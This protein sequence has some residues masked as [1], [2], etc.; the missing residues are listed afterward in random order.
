MTTVDDKVVYFMSLCDQL[1][2]EPSLTVKQ[3]ILSGFLSRYTGSVEIL[4]K[5]LLPAHTHRKYFLGD[6]QLVKILSRM[7]GVE[8]KQMKDDLN[9]CGDMATTAARFFKKTSMC[10]SGTSTRT[11]AEI[12]KHLE[13]LA[14]GM[15]E[16]HQTNCI[17]KFCEG[18][19]GVDMEVFVRQIKQEMRLNAGIKCILS[20]LHPMAYEAFKTCANVGAVVRKVMGTS[21]GGGDGEDGAKADDTG[22]MSETTPHGSP[23]V[24]PP[25]S[26]KKKG[27]VLDIGIQLRTP[28]RP[29]LATATKTVEEVIAKCPNTFFSEVKYDGERIQIH[30][31]GSEYTFWARSLKPMK[32]DKYEGLDK[33]LQEAIKA[34]TCILDGEILLVDTKTSQ[35]LPFGT[36]G[37]HKK[38]LFKDANTGIFLFDILYLNGVSLLHQPL[39][40]RRELLKENVTEIKNRIL[41]SEMRH[42]KGTR[43]QQEFTLR[44]HL[45]VAIVE[46]LEGLVIKDIKSVYE[47]GMR[48]WIKI[49]KDYLK[50]MADTV[51][52]VVLGAWHGSGA[53]GGIL[54]TF[55][56]GVLDTTKTPSVWYTVC[57]VA[58]GHDDAALAAI[59]E[60][61][62]KKMV[63]V[64][65]K[66]T[67]KMPSWLNVHSSHIP[68]MIMIDPKTS[69]V[70]EVIGAQ[71]TKSAHHTANGI[72]FRFPRVVKVRD[73][74][75]WASATTLQELT[76]LFEVSM[77][78]ASVCGGPTETPRNIDDFPDDAMG[79]PPH[80]P[81]VAVP[82]L[83][84]T[85]LPPPPK[86]VAT[87]PPQPPPPSSST[88][89]YINLDVTNLLS[90][91]SDPF[92]NRV[93][94]HCVAA[95]GKWSNKGTMGL[96]ERKFGDVADAYNSQS[97]TF[98]L[99]DIQ[100]VQ[101]SN[102]LSKGKLY[103]LNLIGQPK[104][105]GGEGDLA[106]ITAGLEKAVQYAATN[107]ASLHVDVRSCS[108][109][110][111]WEGV[112][113]NLMKW[114][115]QAGVS[116]VC[117][118]ATDAEVKR[119]Q[120]TIA[121]PPVP[122]VVSAPPAPTTKKV[123][124]ETEAPVSY[125][126]ASPPPPPTPPLPKGKF[127]G[128]VVYVEGPEASKVATIV[129]SHGGKVS[130]T[131][132]AF[133]PGAPTH[134][135]TSTM[136]PA[137]QHAADV[138]GCV[139]SPQWVYD[140]VMATSSSLADVLSY[141]V[142]DELSPKKMCTESSSADLGRV[143]TGSFLLTSPLEGKSFVIEGYSK[144]DKEALSNKITMLGGSVKPTWSSG[145]TYLI[146]ETLTKTFEALEQRGVQVVTRDW[147]EAV[148]SRGTMVD[149]KPY[150]YTSR[151]VVKGSVTPPRPVP[152]KRLRD[153]EEDGSTLPPP[154]LRTT[155]TTVPQVHQKQS[156]SR[157]SSNVSVATPPV[158][159]TPPVS[160][161]HSTTSTVDA[162]YTEPEVNDFPEIYCGRCFILLGG[163]KESREEMARHIVAL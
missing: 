96:L 76:K 113:S 40:R 106:A 149:P 107:K 97:S 20:A 10:S 162:K 161:T 74:K 152:T 126:Y 144:K 59:N 155:S 42:A 67:A 6:K 41:Y 139:V 117:Y 141:Y 133:G 16:D 56:M 92:E 71:F 55:L 8:E 134:Y 70:W 34:D 33:Y 13:V 72:S 44:Q 122:T 30:K 58:N 25:L 45:N 143:S 81:V 28:I 130:P 91:T 18:A 43:E 52:L 66:A 48:H 46:G 124:A 15:S 77:T 163:D 156:Q 135:I 136:T 3:E 49:K 112:N 82:A 140:S 104:G 37:K 23:G 138:G 142:E 14:S 95:A 17:R 21:G 65:S 120:K 68:E 151:V 86:P 26:P 7:F 116:I 62:K 137:A 27:A 119:Y 90:T 73:D 125:M 98:A 64:G 154:P 50:G 53:K 36:L 114:S 80:S 4:Y 85:P 9:K 79:S 75:D 19:C 123:V 131:W 38:L 160:R 57:K 83:P 93:I 1:S 61:M 115:A 159:A 89:K 100:A 88:M 108:R 60:E 157:Q 132:F 51:D 63:P 150:K 69:P 12:D 32:P 102:T 54:S 110:I 111:T 78:K 31:K 145:C 94:V 118:V 24:S 148:F 84:P 121:P 129:T 158:M 105:H 146:C 35:P 39:D 101:V 109:G 11:L 29:M 147:V 99:G 2:A 153:G 22:E 5:F 87:P 128:I 127:S 47:P 103:V